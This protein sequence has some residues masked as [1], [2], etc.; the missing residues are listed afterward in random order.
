MRFRVPQFIETEEKIVGPFTLKQFIWVG[1]GAVL[2]FIIFQLGF[3]PFFSILLATPVVGFAA[4]MAFLK[5][6]GIP[7]PSY[8]LQ[9]FNFMTGPKRYYFKKKEEEPY[10]EDLSKSSR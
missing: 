4:A 6:D 5:V 10:L 7:L 1:S 3:A 8:M 2:L 9:A